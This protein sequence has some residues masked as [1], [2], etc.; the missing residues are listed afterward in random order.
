MVT[1]AYPR[2]NVGGERRGCLLARWVICS[3]LSDPR[4]SRLNE[5]D[6]PRIV[7]CSTCFSQATLSNPSTDGL[8]HRDRSKRG[9]VDGLTFPS[10]GGVRAISCVSAGGD[11]LT[12]CLLVSMYRERQHPS[13]C[14]I[15][16]RTT[17]PLKLSPRPQGFCRKFCLV[18]GR[19]G[20]PSVGGL[21]GQGVEQLAAVRP[22]SPASTSSCFS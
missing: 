22:S 3:G 18:V 10:S 5:P 11:V 2:Q 9:A 20:A 17:G 7:V 13:P 12:C 6:R 4:F 16:R 21:G 19:G 14:H 1:K 8:D 15:A